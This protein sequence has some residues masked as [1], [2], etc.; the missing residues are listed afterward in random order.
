MLFESA[1]SFR[2]FSSRIDLDPALGQ[3]AY[4]KPLCFLFTPEA[5]MSVCADESPERWMCGLDL[6]SELLFSSSKSSLSLTV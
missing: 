6:D 4:G 3:V 1:F 5:F 2:H